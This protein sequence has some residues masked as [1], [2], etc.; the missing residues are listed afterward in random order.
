MTIIT[1]NDVLAKLSISSI[2]ITADAEHERKHTE[3]VAKT[4]ANQ[5]AY[6]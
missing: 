6:F 4:D 5:Y 1:Q 2:V 3:T